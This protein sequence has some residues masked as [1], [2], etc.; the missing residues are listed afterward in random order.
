MIS[1][2]T[3]IFFL[4]AATSF[5]ILTYRAWDENRPCREWRHAHPSDQPDA[6]VQQQDGTSTFSFNPCALWYAMPPIDFLLAWTGFAASVAFIA[7]LIQDL[8]RWFKRRR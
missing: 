5:G 1:R 8:I 3:I 4:I 6:P 2:R 7:S